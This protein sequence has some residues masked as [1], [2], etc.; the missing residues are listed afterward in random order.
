MT[1]YFDVLS[2]DER[3]KTAYKTPVAYGL[4]DDVYSKLDSL[5]KH[6]DYYS[7]LRDRV[8][9]KF[10]S[11]FPNHEWYF[12]TF[13][14]KSRVLKNPLNNILDSFDNFESYKKYHDENF[15]FN[16]MMNN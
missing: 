14:K 4:F 9:S 1:N 13:V 10:K 8:R 12:E 5:A 3:F 16:I 11:E 15:P 6:S 2:Y 7:I